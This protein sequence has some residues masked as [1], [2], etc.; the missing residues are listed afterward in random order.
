MEVLGECIVY[1][2]IRRVYCRWKYWES[3]LSMEVLGECIVYGSI[4]RVYCRW[5]Y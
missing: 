5:K 1:G 4:R 2:S 3:V